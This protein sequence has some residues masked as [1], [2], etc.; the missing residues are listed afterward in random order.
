MVK[1]TED[2]K[3]KR[4]VSGKLTIPLRVIKDGEEF[5]YYGRGENTDLCKRAAAKLALKD[6]GRNEFVI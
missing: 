4:F 1:P 3:L 5:L 6:L 2:P